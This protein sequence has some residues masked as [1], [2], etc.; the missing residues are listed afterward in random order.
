MLSLSFLSE[1]SPIAIM[2][3]VGWWENVTCENA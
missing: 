3:K 2:V 1:A